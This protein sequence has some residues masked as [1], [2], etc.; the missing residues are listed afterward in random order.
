MKAAK[1]K[2]RP[3]RKPTGKTPLVA[4]R[5]SPAV[6]A[7]LDAWATRNGLSRSDAI[8]EMIEMG[9]SQQPSGKP[10]KG[11]AKAKDM[12]RVVLNDRMKDLPDEERATRKGRLLKGPTG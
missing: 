5:L 9:L 11:A 6:T 4:L 12:A 10:H 2:G 3:G 1:K 8:R 7:R